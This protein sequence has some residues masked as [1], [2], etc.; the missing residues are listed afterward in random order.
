MLSVTNKSIMISVIML[1]VVRMNVIMLNVV[2]ST[3]AEFENVQDSV[4]AHFVL[5]TRFCCKLC[6]Q[7]HTEVN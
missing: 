3:K 6:I 5:G 2:A 1:N 4:L 7:F